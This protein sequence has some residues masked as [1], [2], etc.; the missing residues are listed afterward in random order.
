M[1]TQEQLNDE[2]SQ[3]VEK[4]QRMARHDDDNL[5]FTQGI[6]IGLLM[7]NGL[8]YFKALDDSKEIIAKWRK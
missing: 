4:L 8:T 2:I 3:A 1:V 7:A 6:L 5:E